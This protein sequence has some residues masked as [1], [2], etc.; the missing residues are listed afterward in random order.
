MVKIGI[1]GGT[2]IDSP[3]ILQDKMEKHVETPWGK[4]AGPL[5][6]GKIKGVDVVIISRHGP[7][8]KFNPTNVPYRANIWALKEEGCTHILAPSAVGSLQEEYK[9]GDLVFTDQVIDRTTKREQTFYDCSH[10]AGA[11]FDRVCHIS[12]AEPTSRYLR[13]LAMVSAKELAIPYH[14]TGTIVVIEGPRFSTKA[15]SNLFRSWNAHI[16]GMTAVPEVFLARE[17]Q[18]PY[19][20]IAMVTDYDV[21]R[22]SHVTL[23]EVLSTMA[24]NAEKVKQLL[25]HMIPRIKDMEL[26]EYKALEGALL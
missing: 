21:W 4:P 8:H 2:G 18:I 20:H 19:L 23:D 3:D 1:I 24:K 13:D 5:T 12:V 16:I 10:Q 11:R 17:A 7:G 22:D 25:L 14:E 26:P 15:E 9:P 6:I